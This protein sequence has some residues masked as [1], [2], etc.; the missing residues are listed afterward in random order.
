MKEERIELSDSN[1]VMTCSILGAKMDDAS[2]LSLGLV[3]KPDV[4]GYGTYVMKVMTDTMPM[5][6]A[7]CV[8]DQL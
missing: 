3:L 8:P 1:S 6:T 7:F 4:G 5:V 2:G